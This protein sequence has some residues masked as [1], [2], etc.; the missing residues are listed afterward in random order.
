[1]TRKGFL[2]DLKDK[3]MKAITKKYLFAISWSRVAEIETCG[4]YFLSIL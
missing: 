4:L 2:S 1:V 3:E